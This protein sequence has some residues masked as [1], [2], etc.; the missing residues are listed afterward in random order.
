MSSSVILVH[1][2]RELHSLIFINNPILWINQQFRSVLHWHASCVGFVHSLLRLHLHV[3]VGKSCPVSSRK[4]SR[5]SFAYLHWQAY[6]S[7]SLFSVF[8]GRPRAWSSFDVFV[9]NLVCVFISNPRVW[10]RELH[11]YIFIN[12]PILWIHQQFCS[13]LDWHTL[14]WASSIVRVHSLLGLHSH[15]FIGK[16]GSG[17]SRQTSRVVFTGFIFVGNIVLCIYQ[18]SCSVSL[19][20]SFVRGFHR[21]HLHW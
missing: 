2:L 12:K 13:V 3:F 10:L 16:S 21:L 4:T 17:A 15:D 9:P 8:I 19:S 18:Q 14:C 6:S 20:A 5:S 1:G 7:A 11:L